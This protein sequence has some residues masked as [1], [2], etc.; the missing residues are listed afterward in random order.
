MAAILCSLIR[1]LYE[2]SSVFDHL[3]MKR[4]HCSQQITYIVQCVRMRTVWITL[5]YLG[6]DLWAKFNFSRMHPNLRTHKINNVNMQNM[7][8]VEAKM[9]FHARHSFSLF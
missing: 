6:Y 3:N 1:A 8:I 2:A 4:C 9:F 5:L 7:E